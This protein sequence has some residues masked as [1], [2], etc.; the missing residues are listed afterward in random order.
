MFLLTVYVCVHARARV[1]VHMC[2]CVRAV[3]CG[4]SFIKPYQ[5]KLQTS[6]VLGSFSLWS[7]EI[8]LKWFICCLYKKTNQLMCNH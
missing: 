5:A 8:T 3:V 4:Y 2:V 6:G 7:N 1:C